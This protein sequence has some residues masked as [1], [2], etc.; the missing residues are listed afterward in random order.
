[1]R[2]VIDKLIVGDKDDKRLKQSI[3]TAMRQGEGLLMVLDFQSENIRHYSKRLMC[4]VTGLSY[5]E[6]APHNFSFNSPQGACPSAK[7][8]GL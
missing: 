4:P 2:C 1:L 6:P 5:K 8:W 7:D 3:A